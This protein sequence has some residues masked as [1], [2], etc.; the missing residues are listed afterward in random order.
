MDQFVMP[1]IIPARRPPAARGHIACARSATN[2][3]CGKP[4]RGI[5]GPETDLP[6][7]TEQGPVSNTRASQFSKT[8]KSKRTPIKLAR[9]YLSQGKW[10]QALEISRTAL[11]KK[12]PSSTAH[13]QVAS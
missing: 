1:T 2:R 9:H 4:C 13:M 12:F 11:V 8:S 7:S 3:P 5:R 10:E 6:G